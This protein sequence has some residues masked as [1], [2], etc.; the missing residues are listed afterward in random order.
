MEKLFLVGKEAQKLRQAHLD[1][2][3]SRDSHLPYVSFTSSSGRYENLDESGENTLRVD[4]TGGLPERRL[5]PEEIL[6]DPAAPPTFTVDQAVDKIGFGKFQL[7]L[8]CLAGF[9]WMADAMEMM[10]LSILSPALK[11]EWEL[12]GWQQAL[13]TTVVFCGMMLSSAIWGKISDKY[14]RRVE[15]LICSF[16]TFFYGLISAFAPNF[17]WLLFLRGF[18]GIGIGGSP[19]SVTLYSEFLPSKQR[20]KCLVLTEVFWALGSCFEV[21]LA[22]FVMPTLGWR[23]LLGLSSI[24]LIIFDIACLWM[25]ESA[26]YFM[27][28]GQTEKAYAVLQR[29]ANENGQPMP[30]G[31]LVTDAGNSKD[32]APRGR[33]RDL[34]GPDMRRT[35]LL[36]WIIWLGNAFSYYGIVL[37]TTELFGAGDT[38]HVSQQAALPKPPCPLECRMLSTADYWDLLWTTVAEFPGTVRNLKNPSGYS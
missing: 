18:V 24:P 1:D 33:F 21:L 8:S 10:I 25:P 5:R 23:W 3:N 37:M 15:L 36:L 4:V 27:A 7:K 38:C 2:V 11:C 19:Q 28:S 26:R 31:E 20:A 14:G 34:V 30:P 29:I 9:A 32:T 13:V 12:D 6:P 16:I 22:L 35:T 17:L